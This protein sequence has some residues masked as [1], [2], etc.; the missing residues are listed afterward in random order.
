MAE[1]ELTHH[2]IKGMKWGVR[3]YQPYGKGE[4]GKFLGKTSGKAKTKSK[5]VKAGGSTPD[6]EIASRT[7]KIN[8]IKKSN[9]NVS[10]KELKR[11]KKLENDIRIIKEVQAH[12]K[13]N[14]R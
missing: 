9:G 1:Q 2:G 8:Q 12:E 5:N 3:R 4:S 6:S 11:I 14:R 10:K 7:A 13:K